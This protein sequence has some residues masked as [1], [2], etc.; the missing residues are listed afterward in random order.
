MITN[1]FLKGGTWNLY[2][3]KVDSY[4]IVNVGFSHNDND[5]DE[6]QFDISYPNICELNTLFNNFVAESKFKIVKI[7]YV[8]VVK[9]AHTRYGLEEADE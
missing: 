8:N 6:T 4:A 1:Y 5:E 7:L 9:S 2:V 3:D